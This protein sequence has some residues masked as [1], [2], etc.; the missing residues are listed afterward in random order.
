MFKLQYRI[1]PEYIHHTGDIQYTAQYR[2]FPF[3]WTDVEDQTHNNVLAW[4]KEEALKKLKKVLELKA[5]LKA[6]QREAK[7]L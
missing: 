3:W 1:Y 4:N 2:Y 7:P 5:K 6:A